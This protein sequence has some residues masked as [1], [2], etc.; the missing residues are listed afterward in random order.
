MG[1]SLAAVCANCSV[2]RSGF[3]PFWG[4][5][6]SLWSSVPGASRAFQKG[7][8]P[9]WTFLKRKIASIR[10]MGGHAR[11]KWSIM[12]SMLKAAFSG[13]VC[14][15]CLVDG[16]VPFFRFFAFLLF[17]RANRNDT[18]IR[19]YTYMYGIWVLGPPSGRP[20]GIPTGG[21]PPGTFNERGCPGGG[22]G[23]AGNGKKK[24]MV[25]TLQTPVL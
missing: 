18:K 19:K 11:R 16:S 23:R 14:V 4:S 17:E 1:T 2:I 3:G 22:W 7:H 9:K 25:A 24:I 12:S 10:A 15:R 6:G 21:H 5:P 8:F 13:I 20:E